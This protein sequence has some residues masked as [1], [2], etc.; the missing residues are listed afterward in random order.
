VLRGP[1][2]CGKHLESKNVKVSL[3][4]T[5]APRKKVKL[6]DITYSTYDANV[7][8][9]Y[10]RV[11]NFSMRGGLTFF[12]LDVHIVLMEYVY[13]IYKNVRQCHEFTAQSRVRQE[14]AEA[15]IRDGAARP[16]CDSAACFLSNL[17]DF[18]QKTMFKFSKSAFLCASV[19]A[20]LPEHE[21]ADLPIERKQHIRKRIVLMQMRKLSR[22]G[23][24]P[25]K[26][27]ST[28]SQSYDVLSEMLDDV[29]LHQI[30]SEQF[31]G[32]EMHK[33][34]SQRLHASELPEKERMTTRFFNPV[35]KFDVGGV[36]VFQLQQMIPEVLV[37]PTSMR[38]SD[39]LSSRGEISGVENERSLLWRKKH[40]A[41]KNLTKKQV[42]AR[43][44]FLKNRTQVFSH[45]DV[46]EVPSEA[47]VVSPSFKEMTSSD[48]GVL[49]YRTPLSSDTPRTAKSRNSDDNCEQHEGGRGSRGG[50]G[51]KKTKTKIRYMMNR[52]R[53]T[54]NKRKTKKRNI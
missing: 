17:T 42:D 32:V 24:I 41:Y 23:I 47:K 48:S 44:K 10:S 43:R 6:V 51:L 18:E 28:V 1:G 49:G 30:D 19:I 50:R 20:D 31:K 3:G 37:S 7:D 21:C 22:Y 45:Q 39:S 25:K 29:I 5:A 26:F 8:K 27:S 15:G 52:K 14:D 11:K 2:I 36:P 4:D 12:Y 53:N 54:K 40:K 34:L 46:L 35:N 16:H 33:L 9:L 13:I 38:S